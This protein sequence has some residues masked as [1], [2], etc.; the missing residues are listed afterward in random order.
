MKPE[1]FD[2]LADDITHKEPS[3]ELDARIAK[4]FGKVEKADKPSK[5]A[6][7]P[8][9]VSGRRVP[10]FTT[11]VGEGIEFAKKHIDIVDFKIEY[12]PTH[13]LA[14]I[15]TSESGVY[16]NAPTDAQALA[17]ALVIAKQHGLCK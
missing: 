6:N 15:K 5:R 16:S 8:Q 17:K 7:W 14:L 13:C 11:N 1:K 4:L 9:F 12:R 10:N 3:R 2:K